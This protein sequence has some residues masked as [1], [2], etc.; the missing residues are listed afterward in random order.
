[1][2][3]ENLIGIAFDK[4]VLAEIDIGRGNYEA[5]EKKLKQLESLMSREGYG[6]DLIAISSQLGYVHRMMGRLDEAFE[7]QLDVLAR[8]RKMHHG[9]GVPA[10]L[11]ELAEIELARGNREQA[12][13]YWQEAL[14]LYEQLGSERMI[15]SIRM[16]LA[17]LDAF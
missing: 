3:N 11:D 14:G 12:R 16:S 7:R 2:K 6:D 10:V 1:Q 13:V 17:D 9:D 8:A 15:E 5:A 4:L